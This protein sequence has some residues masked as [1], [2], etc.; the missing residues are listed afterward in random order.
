MSGHGFLGSGGKDRGGLEGCAAGLQ[1]ALQ[2]VCA[3]TVRFSETFGY[4]YVERELHPPLC[5]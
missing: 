2:S 5:R 1:L 4:L 3:L